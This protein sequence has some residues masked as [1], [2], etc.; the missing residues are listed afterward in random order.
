[1]LPVCGMLE[2]LPQLPLS[3]H[4]DQRTAY[5]IL[6]GDGRSLAWVVEDGQHVT[7]C[8]LGG[9][10]PGSGGPVVDVILLLAM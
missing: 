4:M 6:L 3:Y 2:V 7:L 10:V 1:M 5:T 8:Q 9:S